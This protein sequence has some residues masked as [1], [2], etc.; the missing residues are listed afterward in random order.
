L[1]ISAGSP[2]LF[3]SDIFCASRVDAEEEAKAQER[4]SIKCKVINLENGIVILYYTLKIVS[5]KKVGLT[6]K[7]FDSFK[8]YL[9]HLHAGQNSLEKKTLLKNET[10]GVIN[11]HVLKGTFSR[12]QFLDYH[13]KLWIRSKLMYTNT[14]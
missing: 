14:F 13:F 11:F 3:S 6:E 5:F 9:A 12:K 1:L 4:R 7:K 2:Q 8:I 10:C